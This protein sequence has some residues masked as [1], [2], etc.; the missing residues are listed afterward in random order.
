MG[1]VCAHKNPA[2]HTRARMAPAGVLAA[3]GH[4]ASQYARGANPGSREYRAAVERPP[5]N[6]AS[7]AASVFPSTSST[8]ALDVV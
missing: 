6:I 7:R 8:C 5:R 2:L 1:L 3:Q 4:S